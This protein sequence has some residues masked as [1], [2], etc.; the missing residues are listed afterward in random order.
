MTPKQ[1]LHDATAAIVGGTNMSL[2]FGKGKKRPAGFPRGELLCETERGNVYSVDPKKVITWLES[3]DLIEN[4]APQ[5][6]R[7]EIEK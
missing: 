1:L 2:V 5:P 6:A 4:P 7:Q 3:N